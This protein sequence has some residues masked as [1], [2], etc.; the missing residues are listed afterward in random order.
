M[1]EKYRLPLVAL[2]ALVVVGVVVVAVVGLGS[3]GSGAPGAAPTPSP[4]LTPTATEAPTPTD[5]RSTPEG[6]TR[7]FFAAFNK[8][9]LTDDPTAVVPYVTS[10]NSSAYQSVSAFLG[11]EKAANKAAVITTQS[12]DNMTGT[13]AADTATVE[14]DYTVG[15]YTTNLEGVAIETPNVLAPVHAKVTLKLVAG[16]WLVDAYTQTP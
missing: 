1:N 2:V 13:V 7:A 11:G 5:P 6:A 14:F 10:T 8:G 15:G 9:W 16:Q 3:L 12:L 4:M